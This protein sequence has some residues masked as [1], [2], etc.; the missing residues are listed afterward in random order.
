MGE[1]WK[2]FL[3]DKETEDEIRRHL[4]KNKLLGKSAQIINYKLIAVQRPGWVQIYRFEVIARVHR[5]PLAE[6]AEQDSPSDADSTITLFGLTKD[7]GRAK[8]K[9]RTFEKR[10]DRLSLFQEWSEGMLL[11]RRQEL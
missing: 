8:L 1:K 5:D 6:T 7:D 2:N 11:L 3:G 9:I 10:E 4:T